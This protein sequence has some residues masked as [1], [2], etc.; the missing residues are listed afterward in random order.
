MALSRWLKP[1]AKRF[2][3]YITDSSDSEN[4]EDLCGDV[5]SDS[6]SDYAS[7]HGSSSGSSTSRSGCSSNRK[8]SIQI[9]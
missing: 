1:P 8:V 2:H 3:V 5:T 7:T 9:G 4:E 6:T